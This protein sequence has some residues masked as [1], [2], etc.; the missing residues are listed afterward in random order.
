M[1][2]VNNWKTLIILKR[3]SSKMWQVSC[4]R[5]CL[6]DLLFLRNMTKPRSHTYTY[7]QKKLFQQMFD[8]YLPP[9]QTALK[10]HPTFYTNKKSF[11]KNNVAQI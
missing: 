2:L 11:T 5:L 1:A 7:F 4:T 9:P 8:F 3:A 6:R 10:T